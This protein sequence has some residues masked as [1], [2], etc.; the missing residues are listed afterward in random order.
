MQ[1]SFTDLTPLDIQRCFQHKHSVGARVARQLVSVWAKK[2]ARV[3]GQW[4]PAKKVDSTMVPKMEMVCIPES[5]GAVLG[6][7]RLSPR[8]L[9]AAP[10]VQVAVGKST[11]WVRFWV[12]RLIHAV[13]RER[14]E[15]WLLEMAGHGSERDEDS[16][17]FWG[18]K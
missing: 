4:P 16:V 18:K 1:L 14:T 7:S 15:R 11:A 3:M 12:G 6:R 8:W 5:E 10:E 2:A 9:N 17:R 13:G